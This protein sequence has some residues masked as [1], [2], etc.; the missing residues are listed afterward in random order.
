MKFAKTNLNQAIKFK[1]TSLG[2]EVNRKYWEEGLKGTSAKGIPLALGPD[3][4]C[5]M[6]L[7]TFMAIFGQ[8]MFPGAEL[9]CDMEVF[10][11]VYK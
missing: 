5:E 8:R 2:H 9:V 10:V 7:H 1:P 3:G 4:L 11:E 6:Q